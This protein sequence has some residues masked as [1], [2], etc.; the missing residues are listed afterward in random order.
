MVADLTIT[1]S[2]RK[3]VT[4]KQ[5]ETDKTELQKTN[6]ELLKYKRKVDELWADK[7]RMEHSKL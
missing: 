7:Q 5:L 2:E 6:E 4:I 3:D 1:D